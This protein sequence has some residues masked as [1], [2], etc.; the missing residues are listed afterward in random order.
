MLKAE[1]TQRIGI[2]PFEVTGDTMTLVLV[3]SQTRRRLIFPK[4]RPEHN[5]THVDTCHREGFEE[6]GVRG[7]VLDDFPT[8]VPIGRLTKQGLQY[9]PVTFYPFHVLQVLEEWPERLH[10]GRQRVPIRDAA[11][12]MESE[13][14]A[15]LFQNFEMLTPWV[16]EAVTRKENAL[17]PIAQSN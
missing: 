17:I 16:I 14:Y 9:H 4:G 2:I 11:R 15:Y 12:L 5:E 6:A 10:R 8:T 7:I 1:R 3:T 13:D